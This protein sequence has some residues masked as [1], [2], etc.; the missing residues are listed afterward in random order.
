VRAPSAGW[1]GPQTLGTLAGGALALAVFVA[2]ERRTATPIVPMTFFRHRAFAAATIASLHFYAALFGGL[3][4]LTE[5]LQLGLGSDPLQ[6]GLQTLPMAG[7]PLVLAPV[8]GVLCDRIGPRPLMLVAAALEAAAFGSIALEAHPGMGYGSLILPFLMIG[9]GS[10]LFLAPLPAVTLGAVRPREQGK[11]SGIT[12]TG[13]EIAAVLGVA[14]LTSIQS[15]QH[16]FET[17]DR[18]ITGLVPTLWT[19]T[20]LAVGAFV[21]VLALPGARPA[22]VMATVT[23]LAPATVRG[24]RSEAA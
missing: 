4:L 7:V 13:R 2:W 24:G 11:A 12:T 19:A 8:A 20:G 22:A 5:L 23:P 17:P 6:A 14:V 9:A 21:A 3:F 15:A 18:L 1:L 16:G 10:A